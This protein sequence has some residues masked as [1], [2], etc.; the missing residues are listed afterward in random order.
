MVVVAKS[1]EF[2]AKIG[3]YISFFWKTVLGIAAVRA[4]ELAGV[5]Y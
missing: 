1:G 2:I 5:G 3:L 4:H